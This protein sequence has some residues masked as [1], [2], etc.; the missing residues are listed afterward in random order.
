[1]SFVPKRKHFELM[2][3][4]Y[5][6][7]LAIVAA[8]F[9]FGIAAGSI[10][11]LWG[12]II[13]SFNAGALAPGV[14]RLYWWRCNAWGM[15]GGLALGG[16]GAVAQ[17]F[18]APTMPEWESFVIMTSLSFIGTIGISLL[19]A[20]TPIPVLRNFFRTTRPFGAWGWLMREL[21][22]DQQKALRKEH[23]NDILTVPFA[24]LAQVTLFLM[25][26]QILVKTYGTFWRTLPLFLIGVIG[27]YFFWWRPLPA[28]EPVP[29]SRKRIP[30]IRRRPS[31]QKP[32]TRSSRL[33]FEATESDVNHAATSPTTPRDA[34]ASLSVEIC[35]RIYDQHR[36]PLTICSVAGPTDRISLC[37]RAGTERFPPREARRPVRPPLG[38][39]LVS[40]QCRSPHRLERQPRR[41]ALGYPIRSHPL[42]RRQ[43]R[44]GPEHDLTAIAPTPSC[45][46]APAAAKRSS[47]Q[48]E[49]ACNTKFGNAPFVGPPRPTPAHQPVSSATLRNRPLQPATPG[50][51]TSMPSR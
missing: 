42:D 20:P 40:R 44:P 30:R 36:Y 41:S 21:P 15:F 32:S 38:H 26:M 11:D 2:A 10:N 3:T 51:S 14:L 9:Y 49:M 16:I 46:T 8:G 18:Y 39:L 19:T 37:R 43:K 50:K 4:S 12:W 1:M 47:F 31:W 7:T 28:C 22:A 24:L 33:I 13:M 29:R 27:L 45:S 23:R 17:R 48:I 25:P 5:I 35:A 6:A 34:F